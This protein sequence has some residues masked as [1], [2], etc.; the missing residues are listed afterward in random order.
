MEISAQN[1]WTSSVVAGRTRADEGR[2]NTTRTRTQSRTRRHKNWHRSV[3]YRCGFDLRA[4]WKSGVC[5]ATGQVF[6]KSSRSSYGVC[7]PVLPTRRVQEISLVH[8]SFLRRDLF[9]GNVVLMFFIK[10]SLLKGSTG[11]LSPLSSRRDPAQ[12]K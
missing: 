9:R 5:S 3:P 4:Q 7:S 2:R 8:D 12:P 10:S 11:I 1:N 6:E